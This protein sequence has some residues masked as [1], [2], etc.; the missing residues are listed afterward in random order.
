MIKRKLSR[1]LSFL[2][3]ILFTQ[4]LSNLSYSQSNDPFEVYLDFNHRGIINTVVISYYADDTF[5]LPVNEIFNL[6]NIEADYDGLTISGRFS[7]EQIEYSINLERQVI[8]FGNE[9]Y[10]LEVED[11]Y[12]NELDV[13]LPIRLFSEIFDLNF[14]VDFNQLLLNLETN[15]EL[16]IIQQA[17]RNQERRISNT[18][19]TTPR[20]P[21]YQSRSSNKL[22]DLGFLDYGVQ[23]NTD[24]NEQI[25]NISNSIG[26]NLLGG[27]LSG[28]VFANINNQ[29]SSYET[30]NLRWVYTSTETPLFTNI[31]IGQLNSDGVLMSPY[32][33]I[34]VSN[35][36]I[37]PRTLFDEFEVSG[38]AIPQ[39]EVELYLNNRLVGF[40]RIDDSG[41]YRFLIP[42]SYGNSQIVQK[43]YGPT[44]QVKE[45][46]TRLQIPFNFVPKGEIN[47]NLNIGQLNN[48]IIGS[49]QVNNIG[50]F[51]TS[52]GITSWLTAK[53]GVENYYNDSSNNTFFTSTISSRINTNNIFTL[54]AVSDSYLRGS[55]N[56]IFP[57]STSLGIDYVNYKN[58]SNFYNQSNY[59]WQLVTTTFIPFKLGSV[60]LNVRASSFLRKRETGYFNTL[61]FDLISRIKRLSFR[62]SYS[63]QQ[64]DE[65]N[66]FN[67]SNLSKIESSASYSFERSRETLQFFRGATLRSQLVY[68]IGI[69][70]FK[71]AELFF[72]KNVSENGRFQISVG[73]DFSGDF[74]TIRFNLIFN[75]KNFRSNTTFNSLR[76]AYSVAQS[77]RGS[78]GYDSNTNNIL[79]SNRDQVGRGA[80]STRM[81]LDNNNNRVYDKDVDEIIPEVSLRID[82]SGTKTESKNN[83]IYNSLIQPNI[84]LNVEVNKATIKNPMLVPEVDKFSIITEPNKYTSVDI[85]FFQAGVIEGIVE[86]QFEDGVTD[87]IGGLKVLLTSQKDNTVKELRTF[88]DGSFYDYPLPPGKYT[89]QVD[90]QQLSFLQATSKPEKID[91]EVEAVTNGDF[92]EGLSF[93]LIPDADAE[94][95]QQTIQEQITI[96]QVT[97]EIKSSPEILEY[98]QE[99]F[100]EVDDAL[101]LIIHAQNA[102]YSNNIDLA[103]RFVSESLELFETAQGHALK[104]SFYYFEGNIDQAQRHWE[105]ALRFNPDLV[106]PDMELLEE[107]VNRRASD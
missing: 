85:P 44:G 69:N 20:Y 72:T 92:I 16:P 83:V 1:F 33:G 65:F 91:F 14:S 100:K 89:L 90:N 24:G 63:D 45:Q 10:K 29:I 96:A 93:V 6:F 71:S 5:Y 46:N 61:R 37:I 7:S 8:V 84:R 62:T 31:S 98:S 35:E 19:V 58:N 27:D 57:N 66:P 55:L 97:D 23:Y 22:I 70:E 42:I 101:R 4:S 26:L 78:I 86:R 77:L 67:S 15:V 68:F 17:L 104:G 99:V 13:H 2:S 95:D 80:L 30:D 106:I 102:F 105:Q 21:L 36:P 82:R 81:F 9:S 34:R 74:N 28:N 12:L 56:S 88:S 32:M 47:Y 53:L 39:S 50:Q 76:G 25:L 73:R 94:Q 38:T 51:N 59:N 49:T 64:I 18:T 87:G 60:P 75:F 52:V 41:N 43:I 103:F 3:I 48:F 11:Y 40:S 79:F 54:E 107:R